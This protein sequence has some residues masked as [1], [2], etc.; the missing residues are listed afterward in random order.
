MRSPIPAYVLGR[1]A[2]VDSLD[3][4]DV[5]HVF[6]LAP[7]A[8]WTGDGVREWA[9]YSEDEQNSHRALAQTLGNLAL[10][11]QPLAER[12]MDASFPQKRTAIYPRSSDRGDPRPGGRGRVG[13]RRDRRAHRRA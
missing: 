1:L 3:G 9:D 10:L 2:D 4:L 11:E 12:A 8:A 5:E 6:P 7:G 13:H